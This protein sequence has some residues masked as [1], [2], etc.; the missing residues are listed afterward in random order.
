MDFFSCLKKDLVGGL[1]KVESCTKKLSRL[2]L[3][4]KLKSIAFQLVM[5]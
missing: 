2:S 1:A 4:S 5:S 3:S